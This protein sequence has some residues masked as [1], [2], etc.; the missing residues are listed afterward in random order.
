M[1][2]QEDSTDYLLP[3]EVDLMRGLL[4]LIYCNLLESKAVPYI[5]L[6]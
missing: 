6:Q 3:G 2:L 5:R 4:S 1:Y